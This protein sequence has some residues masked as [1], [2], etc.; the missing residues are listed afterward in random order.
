MSSHSPLA[1][2]PIQVRDLLRAIRTLTRWNQTQLAERIGVS[3]S[4]ISRWENHH[5]VPSAIALKQIQVLLETLYLET[6]DQS[7]SLQQRS[8]LETLLQQY[9]PQSTLLPGNRSQNRVPSDLLAELQTLRRQVAL[10][11]A[12]SHQPLSHQSISHQTIETN[13]LSEAPAPIIAALQEGEA[14]FRSLFEA[15]PIGISLV[16]VK[17]HRLVSTNQTFQKMLGYSADE[18]SEMTVESITHP[19]DI[20][21]DAA[22]L[23][24]FFQGKTPQFRR[25][26]RYLS[27]TGTAIWVKITATL[28]C[29]AVTHQTYAL[30]MVEDVTQRRMEQHQR[31]QTEQ[32]L[33]ESEARWQLAIQGSNDGIWDWDLLTGQIFLSARWKATLGFEAHELA[34]RFESWEARIHPE[35]R[36]NTLQA[37]QDYLEHKVPIY[38]SEHRLR[39]KDG[40]YKWILSRG[41]ALWDETGRAVRLVGSHTDI[42]NRKRIETALQEREKLLSLFVQFAPASVAML[43]RDMR[44][45]M[46]SQRWVDDFHLESIESLFGQSHYEVFPEISEQWR[47]VHQRCLAGAIEK[48]E[49]DL[50]VRA[51]GSQQWLRW[52]IY[53]WF[54]QSQV[55]RGIIIFAEDI[56][57]RKLAQQQLQQSEERFRLAMECA[58]CGTW[59][60]D[61]LRDHITW[62]DQN[63]RLHGLPIQGIEPSFA[64]WRNCIYSPDLASAEPSFW[65][66]LSTQSFY[67]IEYRVFEQDGALRWLSSRGRAIYDEAGQPLR[68]L[69]VTLDINDR[70]LAEQELQHAIEELT[71][72]NQL[73]DDFLSTVSH[74]L[75]TPMSNIK[76]ATQM[77]EVRLQPL[78]VL[79]DTS[80]PINRYFQILKD[81]CQREIG[82]INDLLD[83]ARLDAGAEPLTL[84]SVDLN[85]LLPQIVEPFRERMQNHQQ[86]FKMQLPP[87]LPSLYLDQSYLE[88]IVIELLNNACKYTPTG[89]QIQIVV[90]ISPS[91]DLSQPATPDKTA[92]PDKTGAYPAV[93]LHI[94]NSGIEI[95]EVEQSR[96]FDRFYRIPNHDPW[97]YGGTGLGL[98]LVKKLAEQLLGEITVNSSSDWTTFTL[99]LPGS[100][101]ATE[102]QAPEGN[103]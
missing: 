28:I 34:D 61:V 39:C 96:I 4:T 87:T 103:T 16:N 10:L 88:R 25:E 69:G 45:V 36:A 62:N 60:W 41:Q 91:P 33:R 21:R 6:L 78:G 58:E 27:K 49:E 12:P 54:D 97:R 83:L 1:L 79:A 77:L 100:S 42:S 22:V 19:E 26:K 18:L 11:T 86:H 80:S 9:F 50:F 32:A 101:L 7:A 31:E 20:A 55:V 65:H 47:Y 29:D 92:A 40:S 37:L 84:T 82:L 93:R 68:V 71:R 59:D 15:A 43:D 13:P 70:K 67:H 74:E 30:A 57:L 48:C 23:E 3:F 51:D 5:R 75:R 94:R 98:A 89:E 2:S 66:A 99:T 76:M 102:G 73:K 35:D 95:T 44:Y 85:I 56:T 72:L 38:Q 17:T 63:F 24:Q 53:P 14:W 52:E 90:E 81:E 46:A 64:V 8:G